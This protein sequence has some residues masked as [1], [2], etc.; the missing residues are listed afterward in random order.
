[1]SD[2]L[3]NVPHFPSIKISLMNT[4]HNCQHTQLTWKATVKSSYKRKQRQILWIHLREQKV[5]GK[6]QGMRPKDDRIKPLIIYHPSKSSK[7]A[8]LIVCKYHL[9]FKVILY[10]PHNFCLLSL[11]TF[12]NTI[13]RHFGR[14]PIRKDD[15]H[16]GKTSY[17]RRTCWRWG[18]W[19]LKV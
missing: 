13:Y 7:K 14:K 2:P 3:F 4:S 18:S 10:F 9:S 8:N 6:S 19:D 16:S 17:A 15:A 11:H 12:A 5:S 1:M